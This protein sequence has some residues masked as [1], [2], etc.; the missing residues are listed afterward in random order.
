MPTNLEQKHIF[1]PVL[2]HFFPYLSAHTF[3]EKNVNIYFIFLNFTTKIFMKL[4]LWNFSFILLYAFEMYADPSLS[5]VGQKL[6]F[7]LNFMSQK[8]KVKILLNGKIKI[9]R[10]IVFTFVSEHCPFVGTK[11]SILKLLRG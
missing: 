11:K 7:C 5:D 10:K 4:I 1:A 2:M 3:L 8:V 6:N 9:N